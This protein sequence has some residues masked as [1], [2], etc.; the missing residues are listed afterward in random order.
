MNW[1]T[2]LG[3]VI[4]VL[5][6][7]VVN[8]SW[9]FSSKMKNTRN[10]QGRLESQAKWVENKPGAIPAWT[11]EKGTSLVLVLYSEISKAQIMTRDKGVGNDEFVLEIPTDLAVAG[12][13]LKLE[14]FNGYY[15]RGGETLNF[16]S[17]TLKGTLKW[18]QCDARECKGSFDFLASDPTLD[19][20]GVKQLST[21]GAFSV[22]FEKKER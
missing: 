22:A 12:K 15:Q 2:K 9:G 19:T 21:A 8:H 3:G 4:I 7:A 10:Y 11:I 17:R 14:A 13:I 18:E 20:L 6:F 16:V 1:Q 5:V